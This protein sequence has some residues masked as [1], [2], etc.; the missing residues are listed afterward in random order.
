[1]DEGWAEGNGLDQWG[2]GGVKGT[3]GRIRGGLR[4]GGG[5]D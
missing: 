1:M 5:M 4:G 3:M 2:G